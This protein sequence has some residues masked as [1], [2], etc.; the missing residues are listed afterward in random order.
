MI[1]TL[2]IL[3]ISKQIFGDSYPPVSA[4][5]V[6]LVHT[7]SFFISP[8]MQIIAATPRRDRSAK[9]DS[10]HSNL[11]IA[12][13]SV[14]QQPEHFYSRSYSLSLP[15][16]SNYKPAPIKFALLQSLYEKYDVSSWAL[17]TNYRAF[18]I[19]YHSIYFWTKKW[20]STSYNIL[21]G[22]FKLIS[23]SCIRQSIDYLDLNQSDKLVTCN[24]YL[25]LI[26]GTMLR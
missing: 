24:K 25:G 26:V 14:I 6:H 20:K 19:I 5:N 12:Q 21:A 15:I 9:I 17:Y 8:L 13:F 10:D 1:Y 2:Q 3:H 23:N 22:Y 18:S 7:F 16:N 11:I 4:N